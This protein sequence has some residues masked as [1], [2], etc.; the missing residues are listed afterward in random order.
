MA[1]IWKYS[2]PKH[3]HFDNATMIYE[4]MLSSDGATVRISNIP[5]DTGFQVENQFTW[6]EITS[7]F[8]LQM[9]SMLKE[10]T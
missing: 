7:V 4:K 5:N 8:K 1:G 6:I 9:Q 2:L 3:L 10:Y